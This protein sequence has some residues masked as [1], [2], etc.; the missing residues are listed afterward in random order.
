MYQATT[1]YF[2][3][4]TVRPRAPC[5]PQCMLHS[6]T[7]LSPVCARRRICNERKERYPIFLCKNE[8]AQLLY[9]GPTGRNQL[10]AIRR[11]KNN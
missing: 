9:N 6:D 11:V 10:G 1:V 3:S 7:T 4:K 8:N 5:N 2:L